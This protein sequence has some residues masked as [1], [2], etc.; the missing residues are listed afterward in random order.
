MS[1][2]G[3]AQWSANTGGSVALYGADDHPATMLTLQ[4]GEWVRVIGKGHISPL[5][6]AEDNAFNLIRRGDVVDHANARVSLTR[7]ETWLT[8]AGGATVRRELCPSQS[9]GP[10][11]SIAI[12]DLK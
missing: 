9:Q 4:L 12:P 10:S 8:A 5:P 6:T 2:I 1:W 3:G 7:A 11:V